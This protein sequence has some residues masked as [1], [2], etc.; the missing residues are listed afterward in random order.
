M[1]A[2]SSKYALLSAEVDARTR[3]RA[4]YPL[5]RDDVYRLARRYVC[6]LLKKATA[7]IEAWE[8][9]DEG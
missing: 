2:E 3:V 7:A 1:T 9:H 6:K 8:G 5:H 4:L